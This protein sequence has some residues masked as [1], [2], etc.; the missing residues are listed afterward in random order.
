[1]NEELIS[2]SADAVCAATEPV[3]PATPATTEV[4]MMTASAVARSFSRVVEPVM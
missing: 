4:T 3:T 2:P 1:M